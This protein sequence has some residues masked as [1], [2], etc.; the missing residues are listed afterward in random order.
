MP[1][2]FVRP[3]RFAIVGVANTLVDVIVF[4]TVIATTT[5]SPVY[6]NVAGYSAGIVN[7]YVLNRNWTFSDMRRSAWRCQLAQFAV[8]SIIALGSS[9]FVVWALAPALGAL[10]AKIISVAATF[11]YS[12]TLSRDFVFRAS[13]EASR[14]NFPGRQSCWY[15]RAR[16]WRKR[17]P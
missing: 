11:M 5:V 17:D 10:S 7:S 9:T 15:R 8:V 13:G 16:R 12:Y 6:A 4:T 1:D 14:R 2:I 3:V